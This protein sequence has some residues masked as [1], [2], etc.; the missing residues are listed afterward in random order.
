MSGFP[1]LPG[2]GSG[3]CGPGKTTVDGVCKNRSVFRRHG[4]WV[5]WN[6]SGR[7]EGVLG[8]GVKPFSVKRL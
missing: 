5:V 3:T 7:E 8:L 6:G 4:S 1:S 2:E